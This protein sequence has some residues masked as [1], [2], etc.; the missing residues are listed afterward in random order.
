MV[1]ENKKREFGEGIE[2][3]DVENFSSMPQQFSHQI[4][5]MRCL[6]KCVDY[7]TVEMVEGKIETRVDKQGN[8][9]T[10]Y[11]PDTRRQFIEAITTAKNFMKC[12]FDDDAN[13]KISNLLKNVKENREKWFQREWNWWENLDYEIKQRL[14]LEGKQVIQGMHNQKIF[15]KDSS[16]SEE[17]E[18]WR[19]VLEELNE[20]TKRLKYYEQDTYTA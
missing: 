1:E 13:E 16:I 18:I 7:G 2:F 4:L 19:S 14:T 12:D 9:T 10:K 6:N 15:F 17:L 8:L 3:D 5:I 11:L 20:L